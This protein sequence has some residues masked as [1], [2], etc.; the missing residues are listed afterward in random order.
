MRHTLGEDHRREI[1][2]PLTFRWD[3][4]LATPLT[5]YPAIH[6]D[7]CVVRTQGLLESLDLR[8]ATTAWRLETTDYDLPS[9]LIA[10]SDHIVSS[11]ADANGVTILIIGWNGEE[12]WRVVLP[13]ELADSGLAVTENHFAVIGNAPDGRCLLTTFEPLA[14]EVAVSGIRLP[15]GSF[16]IVGGSDGFWF[17]NRSFEG[18]RWGLYI[19]PVGGPVRRVLEGPVGEIRV[20]G[21]IAISTI[22]VPG[23]SHS[24]VH[25]LQEDGAQLWSA[26]AELYALDADEIEVAV[27]EVSDAGKPQLVLRGTN[28]G[29]ERWRTPI[30]DD[31]P[32]AVRLAADAVVVEDSYSLRLFRRLDGHLIQQLHS[33]NDLPLLLRSALGSRVAVFAQYRKLFCFE[34]CAAYTD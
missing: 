5:A 20:V 30:D 19:T 27:C 15:L 16:G 8:S 4:P 26:P 29:I 6:G 17:G 14:S 21:G 1:G 9:Q 23:S 24:S 13:G 22:G 34:S 2:A 12:R 11:V 7:Y 10:T 25:V 33:P 32:F 31:G 28:D 18:D 3:R